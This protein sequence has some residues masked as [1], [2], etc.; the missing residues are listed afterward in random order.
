MVLKTPRIKIHRQQPKQSLEVT[1]DIKMFSQSSQGFDNSFVFSSAGTTLSFIFFGYLG[2]FQASILISL[3]SYAI[4]P[5]DPIHLE[6]LMIILTLF[7][8]QLPEF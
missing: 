6:L 3:F 4:Q 8:T 2:M 1:F 7:T 5:L